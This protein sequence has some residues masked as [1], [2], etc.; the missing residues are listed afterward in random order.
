MEC[1][2]GQ[3]QE[4]IENREHIV[5]HGG[6]WRQR[7]TERESHRDREKHGKIHRE[8]DK[9]TKE[10]GTKTEKNI[11]RCSHRDRVKKIDRDSHRQRKSST[12]MSHRDRET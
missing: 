11:E 2:P 4:R 8:A 7:N 6:I 5:S 10:I 1:R 3:G 12:D 9:N